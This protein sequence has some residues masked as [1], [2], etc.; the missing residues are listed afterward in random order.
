MNEKETIIKMGLEKLGDY[1][2]QLDRIKHDKQELIDSVLTDEI[3]TRLAEI[4]AEFDPL[5]VGADS[6]IQDL[7]AKIKA[8]VLEYGATVKGQ[9]RQAVWSKGR[10]SWDTKALDVYATIHPE[11]TEWRKVGEPSVSIREV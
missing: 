2:Q 9:Y 11:I 10:T 4:E 6:E 3:K 5:M 7:T 8:A 1:Y